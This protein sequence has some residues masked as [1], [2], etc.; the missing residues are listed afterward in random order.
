MSFASGLGEIIHR[1]E[2]ALRKNM[3][4]DV[5]ELPSVQLISPIHA[6]VNGRH[7]LFVANRHDTFVGQALIDYGEYGEIEW[8]L[9]RQICGKADNVI[10]VGANIGTHT[11]ALA[12]HVAPGRV[13]A[14]EPQPYIFQCLCANV[15]LNSL[16]NVDTFNG[17]CSDEQGWLSLPTVDYSRPGNFGGI[18]LGRDGEK[19]IPTRKLDDLADYRSVRLIKIDVEGMEIEVL[20]GA[21]GIIERMKPAL[22]L[23]ND[24]PARSEALINLLF[25]LDYRLWWHTPRLFNPLNYFGNTENRYG[26]IASFNML[27]LHRSVA[28]SVALQE[29]T[30]AAAHPLRRSKA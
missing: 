19:K 2:R 10:E 27:G 6:L 26:R 18:A 4:G 28:S 8:R 17:G 11:V 22:Y 5:A 9:I 29:V 25:E 30:D 21:K 3:S 1:S 24:R 7:G 15:A 14:V 23:E 20:R 12:K 13:L 16:Q